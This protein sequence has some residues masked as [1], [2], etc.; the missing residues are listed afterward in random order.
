M[1]VQEI[2]DFV[3]EVA[4]LDLAEDWDNVGLLLGG[5]SSEVSSVLTCLTLTPDVATEAIERKAGLIVSHH[6]ILF[7]SV[8]RITTDNPEG[9]MLLDLAAANVA[10]YSPHTGYDSAQNGINRQLAELLELINVGILRPAETEAGTES[11]GAGRHGELP[12]EMT[13]RDLVAVVKHRLYIP[14][15]QFVGDP[16]LVV[17]KVGIA[18]GAAAEFLADAE[19]VGCQALLTGEARFHDCLAARSRGLGMILPGHYATERPAMEHLASR[20][21][22][23]FPTLEVVASESESDPV[24]W[25]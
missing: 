9:R 16:D 8:K 17:R 12:Q 18:C 25:A 21:S 3:G 22:E 20:L 5:R 6:P 7:R 23:R 19:K 24:Q 11:I 14:G 13:L 4:P 2:L 10:V 15:I 1:N